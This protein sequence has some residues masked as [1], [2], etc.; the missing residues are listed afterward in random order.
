[1]DGKAGA[2][3]IFDAQP[4]RPA[5]HLLPW[6]LLRRYRG[7]ALAAAQARPAAY[8]GRERWGMGESRWREVEVRHHERND[9]AAARYAGSREG[10][11]RAFDWIGLGPAPG[12]APFTDRRGRHR[13]FRT[14]AAA[15]AAVD[16]AWSS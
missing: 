2:Q 1:M 6:R 11:E 16:R 4:R 15:R 3:V 7:T 9:G 12:H 13:R 14:A 5:R 10:R 8:T